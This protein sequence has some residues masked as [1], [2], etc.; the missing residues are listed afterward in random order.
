MA[1]DL[2]LDFDSWDAAL[3]GNDLKLIDYAERVAQQV[4]ITLRFWLAEWFLDETKGVPYFE[5][6]L[7]KNPN[8]AH[9]RQIFT[10]AVLSVE[11]V[12]SVTAMELY[13]DPQQRVLVATYSAA[14][15]YGLV[16][17]KEVLNIG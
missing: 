3:I 17:K 15:D 10:E 5:Y 16:T 11:G 14:T 2:A 9:I 12:N 6:I 13:V 4:Q 7:I 8:M 1:F